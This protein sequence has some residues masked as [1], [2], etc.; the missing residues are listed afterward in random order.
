MGIPWE[1]LC[2]MSFLCPDNLLEAG[3]GTLRFHLS[4]LWRAAVNLQHYLCLGLP[5]VWQF[6]V[7]PHYLEY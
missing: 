5:Q 2:A 6:P 1:I 7:Q 4:A 3:N